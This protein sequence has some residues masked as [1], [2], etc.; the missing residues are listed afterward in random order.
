MSGPFVCDCVNKERTCETCSARFCGAC[1]W[2]GCGEGWKGSIYC[3]ECK[4]DPHKDRLTHV[5]SKH[6]KCR[7]SGV[8]TEVAKKIPYVVL[9]EVDCDGRER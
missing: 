4:A 9:H 7:G 2:E 6:C 1:D 8:V 3:A 5:H